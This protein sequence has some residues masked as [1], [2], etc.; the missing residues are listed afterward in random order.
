MHIKSLIVLTKK[1][2]CLLVGPETS[3]R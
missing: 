2:S 3:S 1:R